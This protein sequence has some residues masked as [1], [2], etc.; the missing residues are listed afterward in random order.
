MDFRNIFPDNLNFALV[1]MT[2]VIFVI[3]GIAFVIGLWTRPRR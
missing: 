3:L 1:S 2:T